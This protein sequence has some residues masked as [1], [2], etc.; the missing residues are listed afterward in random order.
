LIDLL[1]IALEQHPP[2]I[3]NGMSKKEI[4]KVWFRMQNKEDGEY[5]FTDISEALA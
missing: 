5:E 3:F 4:G 1:V 2:N